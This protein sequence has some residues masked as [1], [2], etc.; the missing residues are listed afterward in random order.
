MTFIEAAIEILK[1]ARQPL[2]FK[3]LTDIAIARNLLTVVGRQPELTMQ[4]RLNDELKKNETSTLLTRDKPGVFGLRYYP[5]ASIPVEAPAETKPAPVESKAAETGEPASAAPANGAPLKEGGARRGRRRGGRGRSEAGDAA[6]IARGT[7]ETSEPASETTPTVAAES[8]APIAASEPPAPDAEAEANAAERAAAEE[9]FDEMP[10]G[11]LIAPSAGTE[12]IVK[13]DDHRPV[14][15]PRRGDR[16]RG[17]GDRHPQRREHPGRPSRGAPPGAP[18]QPHKGHGR[19]EGGHARPEGGHARP[20]GGRP[21]H[22]RHAPPQHAS[23]PAPVAASP[24]ALSPTSATPPATSGQPSAIAAATAT[25]TATAAAGSERVTRVGLVDSIVDVLRGTDGRPMHVRQIVDLAI[26]RKLVRGNPPDLWRS[27]GA[28][29]LGDCRAR[30]TA[31]LRQ[32]VR[33]T[34]G[35]HWQLADRKLDADLAQ[36]ERVFAD[37]AT[38][39]SEASQVALRRRLGRLPPPAFESFARILLE[40]MGITEVEHVKRGD[41]V[42]YF[43]GARALAGKRTRL[44]IALRPGE[45]DLGRIAVAELRAGLRA[46][47]FD[48]GLLLAPGRLGV[49]AQAE[50]AQGGG[51]VDARDADRLAKTCA[52]HGVGILKRAVAIELLDVE[53]LAELTD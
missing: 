34:G 47:G 36:G 17:R 4:Q 38:R 45:A 20:E 13:G 28:A 31:G 2:H 51:V 3:Q 40:H 12:E 44:L 23:S 22:D 6:S 29:L 26:K 19:P 43:S 30:D 9:L 14:F 18:G 1:Q 27:F 53:L 41:G 52:S 39:L 35:G 25:T 11:P 37:A 5:P 48:E 50:L 49:E 46:R 33:T 8:A 32:R 7:V 21:H 42:N 16:D 15:E 24:T 10:T